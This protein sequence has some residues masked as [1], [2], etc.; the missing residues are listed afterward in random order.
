MSES[1]RTHYDQTFPRYR[2]EYSEADA[3]LPLICGNPQSLVVEIG[4]GMGDATHEIAASRPDI[5]FVGIE[6]HKPGVGKL[7]R[8][9][10]D[11]QISNVR[12]INHDAVEVFQNMIPPQSL[13]GIHVF[14]PDPWPK[15]RH[16][17]RRLIQREF[18]ALAASRLK[19]GGYLYAVTDWEDYA[20]QMLNVLSAESLLENKAEGFHA[21]VPWRPNTA[22]EAKGLAKEHQI[23][24]LF[25]TRTGICT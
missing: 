18:V 7:V 13:D 22:F 11:K 9:L 25:F 23:R 3:N 17:K 5:F 24:E 10:E 19:P 16:H 6:V 21:P 14:F 1:Q 15:K 2:I 20:L 8:S 4:F 12:I